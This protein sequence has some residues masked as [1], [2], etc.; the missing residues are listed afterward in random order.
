MLLTRYHCRGHDQSSVLPAIVAVPA[1]PQE[2]TERGE[3]RDRR[4]RAFT[5]FIGI[6]RRGV[7]Y[8]PGLLLTWALASA[9]I[10]AA[11]AADVRAS[12]IIADRRVGEG[13]LARR[14]PDVDMR[15]GVLVA[16]DGRVLWSREATDT[17][18]IASITKLMTA[19]VVLDRLALDETLGVP[20]SATELG[21]AGA[22]LRAGQRITVREA[23][24]AAL[25]K[26]GNDAAL[27]LAVRV[28]KNENE[29]VKLMNRKAA[30]LG[31]TGTRFANSY[32]LDEPGHYSTAS[33]VATLARYAMTYPDIREFVRKRAVIIGRGSDGRRLEATNRLLGTYRG[34]DGVKTGWTSDAGYSVVASARRG[35]GRFVAVI[36]GADSEQGRFEDAARLLDWGFSRYGAR[37]VIASGS[38][39]GQAEVTDYDDVYVPVMTSR[40]ATPAVFDLDGPIKT[41]ARYDRRIEA[42]VSRDETL[43]ALL[44][45]QND[46]LVASVPLVAGASV[47]RPGFF[48][49]VRI[50]FRRWWR[51]MFD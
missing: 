21:Q 50:D 36:L 30:A 42:P 43:G 25:V 38:V 9:C 8:F 5:A 26:S 32:G 46:R 18:A 35:G 29:F 3:R 51:S 10:P 47:E 13:T 41:T 40:A 45:T 4:M 6:L 14:A 19:M 37:S 31:L 1:L 16:P 23:L 39:V 17:R 20:G 44:F 24:E 2:R 33:D 7:K 28:S 22:G 12:D 49:R 34:A 27:A 11:A 15:A 48:E